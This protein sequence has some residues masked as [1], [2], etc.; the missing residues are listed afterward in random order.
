MMWGR[1]LDVLEKISNSQF[2]FFLWRNIVS[3]FSYLILLTHSFQGV[4]MNWDLPLKE[5]QT[6]RLQTLS[7]NHEETSSTLL[8]QGV[9]LGDACLLNIYI[10]CAIIMLL[11]FV[12]FIF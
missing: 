11:T 1:K 5:K 6:V 12:Y 8:K 10:L 9:M 7:F 4:L 2:M 3:T